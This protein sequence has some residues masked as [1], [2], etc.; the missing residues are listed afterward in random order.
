MV[1]QTWNEQVLTFKVHPELPSPLYH[2]VLVDTWIIASSLPHLKLHTLL[3][4][5]LAV[6]LPAFHWA[7][8]IPKAF[9]FHKVVPSPAGLA[10][11][12]SV[13]Q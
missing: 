4:F 3:L 13:N 5:P 9:K 12:L 1:A 10:Y 7:H 2:L 8:F 11:W 6:I